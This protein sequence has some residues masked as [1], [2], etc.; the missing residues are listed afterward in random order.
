MK[1]LTWCGVLVAVV[2]VAACSRSSNDSQPAALGALTCPTGQV[3][4]N[5]SRFT[6][7][8]TSEGLSSLAPDATLPTLNAKRTSSRSRARPATRL[9]LEVDSRRVLR[10]RESCV[11]N[12][13]DC[14]GNLQYAYTCSDAPPTSSA[15]S[16]MAP[17]TAWARC[18][19]HRRRRSSPSCTPKTRWPACPRSAALRSVETKT[20]TA[21]TRPSARLSCRTASTITTQRAR[22]TT[23]TSTTMS[24]SAKCDLHTRPSGFGS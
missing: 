2:V 19:V 12:R 18:R 15:S 3:P 1:R 20:S 16:A 17:T 13:Q 9:R 24:T 5:F 14:P 21:S 22:P 6:S 4:F 10:R 11:I 23:S 8:M 7:P